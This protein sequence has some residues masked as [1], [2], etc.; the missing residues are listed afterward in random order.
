MY[1]L[2]QIPETLTVL[3]P[4]TGKQRLATNQDLMNLGL[5]HEVDDLYTVVGVF[6]DNRGQHKLGTKLPG[7]SVAR[8]LLNQRRSELPK[9]I[10]IRLREIKS[11]DAST[12]GFISRGQLVQEDEPPATTRFAG[13]PDA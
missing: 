13:E 9:P 11:L 4:V 6:A 10:K 5:F 1:E 7:R 8:G 12:D 3:D 2:R